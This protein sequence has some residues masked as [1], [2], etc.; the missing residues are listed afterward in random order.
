MRLLETYGPA[1]GYYPEPSK[2]IFVPCTPE[3]T[4]ECKRRLA[5]FEFQFRDGSR[6]V[7][8]FIGSDD[9]KREWL[10]PQ[11]QKW[12]AGI[13]TLSRVAKRYPQ[14]AYAGLVKSLQTEWTYLQRVVPGIEGV[15]AP[16]EEAIQKF[17]LPALFEESEANL[18]ALRPLLGLGVGKAGLGVPDP[19]DTARGNLI[20][21]QS[22][23]GAL[24]ESLVERS[25]LNTVVYSQGASQ[26]RKDCRRDRM[27]QDTQTLDDLKA[28][29]SS[30]VERRRMERASETGAW[31]TVMPDRLNGTDLSADEFR[32][33][34]LL[35]FG[36]TPHSLPH[37]CEGC[38][39]RFSVEHAMTCK[40]GGLVLLRHNDLSSEWQELCAQ[41]LSPS[42]VSDEPLI[43]NGQGQQEGG[44]GVG[45]TEP[46]P[47]IRGDVSAHGFWSRGTTAIFD[48]RVT[49]TECPSQR[50]QD[51]GAILKRHEAEK[52]R[53]YLAHCER[54]RKHFTPLVFSVDGMMGVECDAARKRL[55][56]RLST[57]WKRTYSEVCGFV[58]S[59]LAIALV[60]S[61]SRC[62]RW[63]RN[64]S[65]R[66][67]QMPWDSGSGL[68]L[69]K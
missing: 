27:I 38:Q 13:E 57:K 11:I 9:A 48:I 33:S 67:S 19:S 4:D 10:E 14:T 61:A 63:D 59:R 15:L 40:K 30:L 45:L 18:T 64:P 56:S 1:R 16:L 5:E 66:Q 36:L 58:R 29:S 47:E 24:T 52:K 69:Y 44:A 41:A 37:R 32:D 12:V 17:F 2:S 62:L 42:A 49:D 53:K 55:A 20:A 54:Q 46:L 39:Q 34:L 22:I 43:H 50:G 51:S 35:R 68:S 25:P 6:Y 60:R 21:S 28:A 26:I 3:A 31:L 23:T 7:G 8:G 65:I